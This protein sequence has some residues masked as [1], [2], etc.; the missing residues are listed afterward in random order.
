MDKIFITGTS[1]IGKTTLA[2]YIAKK[3]NIPFINGSSTVL[4]KDYGISSHKELLEMGIREPE[5]GLQFQIDLLK[6]RESVLIEGN[7]KGFVTD[8][9]PI[10]NLVYFLYQNAPYLTDKQTRE[11]IDAC[12]HSFHRINSWNRDMKLIYLSRDFL[13]GDAMEIIGNDGKRIQNHYY[14]DMMDKIFQYVLDKD[15]L[16]LQLDSF[17]YKKFREYSWNLRTSSTDIFISKKRNKLE[18]FIHNWL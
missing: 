2:E 11:Y 7:L 13:P 3:R 18:Q 16:K 12:K 10:D 4:W 9:T 15:F 1:G 14:Q 17:N 5:R 6:Y 8:R